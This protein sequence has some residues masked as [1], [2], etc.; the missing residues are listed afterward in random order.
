MDSALVGRIL[1]VTLFVV[2]SLAGFGFSAYLFYVATS[3]Y[4]FVLAIAFLLL[5]IVAG[6]F[7]IYASMWYYRSFLYD[8]Y[9][10]GIRA[11][12]RP[13][14]NFPTVGIIVPVYNEDPSMVDANLS[15]LK[16]IDYPRGKLRFYLA[17]D[18]T[19]KTIAAKLEKIAYR[20][21]IKYVHRGQR[22]GFMQN[23][24]K[25]GFLHKIKSFAQ[26]DVY[27]QNL[28]THI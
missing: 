19:D 12:L 16:R 9:L 22:S 13:L 5:S 23:A 24:V 28:S 20:Q 2:L 10:A 6:F 18:S 8:K 3:A 26:N 21:G 15:Q 7:N 17:D 1:T 25:I 11:K 14:S 4:V 27:T